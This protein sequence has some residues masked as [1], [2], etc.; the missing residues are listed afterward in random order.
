[1]QPQTPLCGIDDERLLQRYREHGDTLAFAELFNRHADDLRRQARRG[2]AHAAEADDLVQSVFVSA[3][4]HARSFAASGSFRGWLHGILRNERRMQQRRAV[5]HAHRIE[6][7]VAETGSMSLLDE[8]ADREGHA[9]LLRALRA[10]PEPYRTVVTLHLHE[11]IGHDAIAA[12]LGR[13]QAAVRKQFQRGLD[14]LRRSLPASLAGALALWLAAPARA[15]A[16]RVVARTSWAGAAALLVAGAMLL[17]FTHSGVY[18]PPAWPTMA[19]VASEPVA[20]AAALSHGVMPR[21][22]VDG[23]VRA[24]T[25]GE[26][27]LVAVDPTGQP[28]RGVRLVPRR[29]LGSLWSLD[30]MHGDDQSATTDN[31]GVAHWSAL[32]PGD[33]AF[34]VAGALPRQLV[35]VTAGSQ[36]ATLVV[37]VMQKVRGRV[38]NDHGVPVAGA[39]I[40]A[41][42]TGGTR[43]VGDL[44]AHTAVDGTFAIELHCETPHVWAVAPGHAASPIVCGGDL[45]REVVL[46]VDR[47]PSALRGMVRRAIPAPSAVA[48]AWFPLLCDGAP[49]HPP[50]WQ[51]VH[52][53][54]FHFT[55][56]APTR[57]ALVL[58]AAGVAPCVRVLD[59]E[60]GNTSD[61]HTVVLDAGH[62][63]AGRVSLPDGRPAVGALVNVSYARIADGL[64]D[65]M[66]RERTVMTGDDGSFVVEHLAAAE[67]LVFAFVPGE[68]VF[69]ARQ[70]VDVP[71]E[72]C[73]DLCLI[74]SPQ[75]IGTVRH[76]DGAPAR[77]ARLVAVPEG[78]GD[79]A[80]RSGMQVATRADA[81]G[82]FVLPWP[83]RGAHRVAVFAPEAGDQ[84]FPCSVATLAAGVHAFTLPSSSATTLRGRVVVPAP[85]YL[86]AVGLQLEATA[87]PAPQRVALSPDGTF[88]VPRVPAGTYRLRAAH[89]E[90]GKTRTPPFPVAAGAPDMVDAPALVLAVPGR[91]EIDSGGATECRVQVR[92]REDDE[93][94]VAAEGE[95]GRAA[96]RVPP[97]SYRVTISASGCLPSTC[98]VDVAEGEAVRMTCALQS[99]VPVV[100]TLRA[101][102]LTSPLLH[103]EAVRVQIFAG[104]RRLVFADEGRAAQTAPMTLHFGLTPGQY[105]LVATGES[106]R[107]LCVPFTVGDAP[108]VLHQE[109]R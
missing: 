61:A 94:V 30:Q 6:H 100:L 39:G 51:L 72:R 92:A 89:P 96:L 7:A 57:G 40:L 16:K 95:H 19:A 81:E 48:V 10:L 97:G 102:N 2:A 21:V 75:L 26:V 45:A 29:L 36:H 66:L 56:L 11:G 67:V 3:M 79:F 32:A 23:G 37:P 54:A 49:A 53:A 33:Y 71:G 108:V 20:A 77:Q 59:L 85:S 47:R 35:V 91:L 43:D 99:A 9:Q 13:S 41:S 44:V 17:A 1:M 86:T 70:I 84:D 76:S 78:L 106:S 25:S 14:L 69:R 42:S 27:R 80:W 52:D 46:A 68:R 101:S 93:L 18:A 4:L 105:E 98:V 15:Q 64:H 82:R 55:D 104:A 24:S 87:W 63:L 107:R 109:L 5:V 88:S 58:A 50:R 34:A 62:R 103:P 74:A 73:C 65:G 38:V 83:A 12:R 90:L 28:I 60:P 8:L 22:A 31:E